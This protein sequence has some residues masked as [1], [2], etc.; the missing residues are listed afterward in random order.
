[1]LTQI[2]QYLR[3]WF[4]TKPDGTSYPKFAGEF[5]ISDNTIDVDVPEGAYIR[6]MG[7]LF[8]DGVH[9]I[10]GNDYKNEQ[11]EGAV[12]VMVIPPPILAADEWATAWMDKNG[13][14]DTEAN[15]PFTSESF[16]GYSYSKGANTN[17]TAGA[18]VFNQAAFVDMLAPWRKI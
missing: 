16:G 2:C 15:S 8:N 7:S 12:W 3:N 17:G 13:G 5:T 1:M 14:A 9:Q 6:I 18:S 4:D 11:F 10:G